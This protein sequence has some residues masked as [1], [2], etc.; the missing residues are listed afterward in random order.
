MNPLFMDPL[1]LDDVY[2]AN[3]FLNM[4]AHAFEKRYGDATLG[5]FYDCAIMPGFISGFAK[6]HRTS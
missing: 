3:A 1:R 6:A 5:F 2:F 4:E